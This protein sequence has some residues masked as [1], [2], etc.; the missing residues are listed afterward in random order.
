LFFRLSYSIIL[1]VVAM[2]TGDHQTV[3]RS[4]SDV[5]GID[6]CLSRLLPYEKLQWIN[7]KQGNLFRFVQ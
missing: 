2:L 4:V 1:V 3:A 6:E 5:L 7:N